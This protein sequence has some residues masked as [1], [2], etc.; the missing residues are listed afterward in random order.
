MATI[1][2]VNLEE[3]MSLE[4]R[5]KKLEIIVNS[6]EANLSKPKEAKVVKKEENPK[7]QKEKPEKVK[8]EIKPM[9]TLDNKEELLME[10]IKNEWQKILKTIKDKKINIYALLVEG[11]LISLA[12]NNLQIGYKDGFGFHRDA[13]NKPDNKEF[14]EKIISSYF[15]RD[16][17]IDFVM[18]DEHTIEDT[19]KAKEKDSTI[20][21]IVDFFGEDIVEIK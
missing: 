11:R 6:K 7:T 12:N 19:E 15:N 8:E 10:D 13:I 3:T 1:K 21:E 18:E 4:E 16:I 2:L 20:Q 14:V 9:E 5:E 17:K